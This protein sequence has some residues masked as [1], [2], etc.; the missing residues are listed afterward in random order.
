MLRIG[1]H[2]ITQ[3]ELFSAM[4]GRPARATI[5]RAALCEDLLSLEADFYYEKVKL[6]QA[7][8]DIY[9]NV[10]DPLEQH[11]VI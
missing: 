11:R 9:E 1:T 4:Q 7:L 3:H 6:T 5:D 8:L 10:C 2:F